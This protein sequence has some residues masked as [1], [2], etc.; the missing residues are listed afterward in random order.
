LLAAPG[1]LQPRCLRWL[2]ISALILAAPALASAAAEAIPTFESLGLYWTPPSNP[3][4]AGCQVRYRPQGESAWREGLPLWYDQR[5]IGGRTPECRG[6]IVQLR[7]GTSYE[8][9]LGLPGQGFTKKLTAA[10]WSESFPIG[11]TIHVQGGSSE[12]QITS[13]GSADGY[14]LYTFPPGKS[15]STLDV[16]NAADYNIQISAPF[17]IVRGLTLRGAKRDAIKI[18]P[19]AHDIVIEGNDISEWGRYSHTSSLT[20]WKIGVNSDSAVSV[21]C[22][23]SARLERLIVQRNKLHHPRYGTNSWDEGHP[24]GSNAIFFED[25]GGNHVF[26]YNEIYSDPDRYFMDPIG[27]GENFSDLGFP[28]ADSDI[29]GNRIQHYLDRA[30]RGSRARPGRPGRSAAGTL[31][32]PAVEAAAA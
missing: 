22:N 7:P 27:G 13:G 4:S 23:A 5:S 16:G 26:R 31:P 30:L 25:C 6:S 1:M 8:V 18:L 20:G 19:G 2:P 11:E 32:A 14:K 28:N 12:L 24:V 17:V 10:T 21:V 3:G 29:Y 15:T 9:E